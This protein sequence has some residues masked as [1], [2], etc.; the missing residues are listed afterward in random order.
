MMQSMYLRGHIPA[1]IASRL[2]PAKDF[3]TVVRVD[4]LAPILRSILNR[5]DIAALRNPESSGAVACNA[6][7]RSDLHDLLSEVTE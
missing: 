5:L 4:L 1:H 2:I 3:A 6:Q 7:A